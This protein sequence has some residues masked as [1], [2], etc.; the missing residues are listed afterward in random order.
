MDLPASAAPGPSI[1]P[2]ISRKV[3][4]E[5]TRLLYRSANFGLFSNFPSTLSRQADP[6]T[7]GTSTLMPKKYCP[8]M[9]QATV[10]I[11]SV[12]CSPFRRC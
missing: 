10:L 3:E 6:A 5:M 4:D 1:D 7:K 8:Q 9:I 11:P 2:G 12:T